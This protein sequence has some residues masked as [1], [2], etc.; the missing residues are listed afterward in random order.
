MAQRGGADTGHEASE[1]QP[2]ETKKARIPP[3][4]QVFALKMRTDYVDQPRFN[5]LTSSPMVRRVLRLEPSDGAGT[6][7][8]V[9]ASPHQYENPVLLDGWVQK[10]AATQ[11]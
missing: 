8:A 10:V 5:R 11:A 2:R 7:I 4:E 6:K 9:G 3:R 1:L